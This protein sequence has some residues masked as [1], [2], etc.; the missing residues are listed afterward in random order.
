MRDVV[1]DV[2]DPKADDEDSY[3]GRSVG[4]GVAEEPTDVGGEA[5]DDDGD[6]DGDGAAEDERPAAAEA[7]GAAVAH[8]ADERLDEEAGDGAT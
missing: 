2:E 6:D 7:A 8:V 3:G 4:S 5:D 1:G